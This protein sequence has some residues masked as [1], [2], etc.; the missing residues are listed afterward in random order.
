MDER[1][2]LGQGGQFH[3]EDVL[4]WKSPEGVWILCIFGVARR[5]MRCLT[6]S[7]NTENVPS[8]AYIAFKTVE[9]ISKFSAEFDGHTF[10][11]KQGDFEIH[12]TIFVRSLTMEL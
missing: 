4:P 9:H 11:D 5:L 3:L 6:S 2:T 8:R 10:R 1:S 12:P 7:P